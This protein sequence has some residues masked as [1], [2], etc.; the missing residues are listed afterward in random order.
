MDVSDIQRQLDM[1]APIEHEHTNNQKL[2]VE[3]ALTA[4]R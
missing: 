3:I 4:F 2:A 1:G